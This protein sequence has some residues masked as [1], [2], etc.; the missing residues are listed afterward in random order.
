MKDNDATKVMQMKLY[1]SLLCSTKVS[2]P[3]I[4]LLEKYKA[5]IND[6]DII[7]IINICIYI[8]IYIAA[9]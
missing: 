8:Y 5:V 6:Q 7:L 9:Y 4:N 3:Y 2:K 1:T